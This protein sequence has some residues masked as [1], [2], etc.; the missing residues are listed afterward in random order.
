MIHHRVLVTGSAGS[1]GRPI[2]DELRSRGH[3]VRG[4][5]L[6]ESPTADE[7]HIG[8][9]HD[10]AVVDRAME[11]MD[12]VIHLAAEPNDCDF[13]SR[14]LPSNIVGVYHVMDMARKHNLRRIV[15]SSSLQAGGRRDETGVM[16]VDAVNP[17]NHYAVTKVFAE[18]I[19]KMYHLRHKMSV[20]AVRIGWFTRNAAEVQRMRQHNAAGV[21]L[22]HRDARRF[23]ACAVEAEDV[24]YALVYAASKP[25]P[26]IGGLDLEPARKLGYEPVDTF[27]E[28]LAFEVAM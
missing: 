4:L 6:I 25:P 20:V 26:G 22:S 5:D 8:T 7:G 27:P 11:S 1:I 24:G 14:L 2:C 23:F 18:A 12:S 9:I 15:L 13:L 3:L 19:G 21:F 16:R 28:G 10:P 17:H